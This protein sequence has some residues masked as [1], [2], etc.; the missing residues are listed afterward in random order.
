M[1]RLIASTDSDTPQVRT[2]LPSGK[3]R[4]RLPNAAA[5]PLPPLKEKKHG[6]KIAPTNAASPTHA[7]VAAGKPQTT[8]DDHGNRAL[9]HVASRRSMS[10][11]LMPPGCAT[12]VGTVPIV[13]HCRPPADRNPRMR[14]DD[15]T[16]V[17]IEPIRYAARIRRNFSDHFF[18][19]RAPRRANFT[20]K[21]GVTGFETSD[22]CVPK[23]S[24]L[25]QAE[26]HPVSGFAC[27]REST[28]EWFIAIGGDTARGAENVRYC[29]N[30]GA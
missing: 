5:M 24:A 20:E 13:C 8:N 29:L 2:E 17:G 11:A 22:S 12:D 30:S 6:N 25:A 16:P 3:W 26:L 1:I 14:P 10:A 28:D 27:D 9:Q 19:E 21:I 15:F 23:R 4:A 7:I 18:C